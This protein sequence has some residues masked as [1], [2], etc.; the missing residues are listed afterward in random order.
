MAP[1]D[2]LRLATARLE[3]L[4]LPPAAA[5][6]LP[7]DRAAAAA[8]LGAALDPDWPLADLHDVLPLHARAAPPDVPFG[9]WAIVERATATVVGDA[10]FLGPPGDDGV[11]EVG[12]SVVPGR[13]RLG[14]ATE[15]VGALV[16]WARAQPR[17]T[18]VVAGCDP[19]NAASIRTLERL[20][21]AREGDVDGQL[22][23]RLA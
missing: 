6:A 5:A 9:I 23:W 1:G 16:A 13:R 4:P 8:A 15:A 10:G 7:G 14:F 21:F 11:V 12:Y 3:L 20:G 18:V 2:D 22:R 17:V 19:G